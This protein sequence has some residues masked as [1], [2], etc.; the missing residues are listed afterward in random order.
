MSTGRNQR[1]TVGSSL[2][3]KSKV[4]GRKPQAVDPSITKVHN[5]DPRTSFLCMSEDR[6][7]PSLNV[8]ILDQSCHKNSVF[9]FPAQQVKKR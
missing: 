7:W 8:F 6:S 3:L 9:W 1:V 5:S 4:A 2:F